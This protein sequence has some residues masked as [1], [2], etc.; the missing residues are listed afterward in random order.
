MAQWVKD[1]L[2]VTAGALVAAVEWVGAL[3]PRT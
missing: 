2:G 3:A 1:S